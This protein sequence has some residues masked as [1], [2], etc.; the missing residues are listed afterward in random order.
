MN[1]DLL[2]DINCKYALQPQDVTNLLSYLQKKSGWVYIAKT[3]DNPYLKIGRTS[4]DPLTRAKTLSSTGVLNE[5]E[6]IFSLKFFNH[7]WAEKIIHKTLQKF[8]VNK[9]FFS[10]NQDISFEVVYQTKTLEEELLGRFLN[11][12]IIKEDLD[13]LPYALR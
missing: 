4:K 5:Y 3:E 11:L 2:Y 8:R 10:L 9:E 13:L 7:I 1:Y 6:I 12:H